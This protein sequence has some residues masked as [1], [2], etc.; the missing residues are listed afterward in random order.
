MRHGKTKYQLNRFTSWREATVKSLVRNLLTYESIKTTEIR[1]K[2]IQPLVEKLITLGKEDSLAH[3][4]RAFDLIQDHALVNRLFA[5]ICPRFKNVPSGCT[6]ILKVG[7]RRGD[8]AEMV[9]LQ[10][11]ELKKK[12]KKVKQVKEA[13]EI[14]EGKEPSATQPPA[15]EKPAAEEK[16]PQITEKTKDTPKKPSKKF[17]GGIRNIF[18]KERDSL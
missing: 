11:T 1:A 17:L 5:E 15:T 10:L 3:K 14:K 9:L 6:R 13:K 8:N 18:K 2:A 16:H 4:R 7:K 12:E